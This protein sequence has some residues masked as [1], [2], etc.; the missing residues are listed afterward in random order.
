MAAAEG[1]KDGRTEN[2]EPKESCYAHK[3]TRRQ[4]DGHTDVETDVVPT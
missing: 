3:H 2:K 4:A 1:A